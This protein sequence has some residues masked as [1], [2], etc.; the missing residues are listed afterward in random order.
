MLDYERFPGPYREGERRTSEKDMEKMFLFWHEHDDFLTAVSRSGLSGT[1]YRALNLHEFSGKL[2]MTMVAQ[3]ESLDWF[4]IT[5][6]FF[7]VRAVR[8]DLGLAPPRLPADAA[9][10]GAHR[11]ELLTQPLYRSCHK[12]AKVFHKK[13]GTGCHTVCL[14]LCSARDA[15]I[16]IESD[17]IAPGFRRTTLMQRSADN[18]TTSQIA[19]RRPARAVPC[20]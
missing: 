4:R 2:G 7:H 17:E 1:V 15:G 3:Q 6:C 10:N 13:F 20:G 5:T 11:S 12:N 19:G 16:I 14:C 9:G 8:P 18:G